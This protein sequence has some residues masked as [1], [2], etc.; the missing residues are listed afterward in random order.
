MM[1]RYA[2]LAASMA[3]SVKHSTQMLC[4]DAL[5]LFMFEG[6]EWAAGQ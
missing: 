1:V 4:Y 5:L 2:V 6:L 3:V